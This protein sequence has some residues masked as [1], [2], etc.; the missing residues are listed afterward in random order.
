MIINFYN[1]RFGNESK[2]K[3]PSSNNPGV[4]AYEVVPTSTSTPKI[5]FSKT[6][7][8]NELF[9]NNSTKVNID[10]LS[11]EINLCL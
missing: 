2:Y 4:G 6:P 10:T 7:R 9:I 3:Q 11:T 8:K 1:W 5:T